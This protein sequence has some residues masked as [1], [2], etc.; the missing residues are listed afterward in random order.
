MISPSAQDSSQALRIN[1]G[2]VAH[3]AIDGEVIIT[4]LDT[5]AY[6]IVVD[7]WLSISGKVFRSVP[8]WIILLV[9]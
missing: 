1:L 3:E 5:G 9:P 4:N 7:A 6:H 2:K 8:P